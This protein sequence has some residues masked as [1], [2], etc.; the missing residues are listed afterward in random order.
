MIPE[1]LIDEVVE[2]DPTGLPAGS[3]K[4]GSEVSYKLKCTPSKL[5]AKKIIRNKYLLPA[6]PAD[7]GLKSKIVIAPIET[8]LIKNC[9]ADAS[10]LATLVIEKYAYHMPVYRQMQRFAQAGVKLA[11]STML[12]WVAKAANLLNPLYD[13]IK[14]EIIGADYLMMDETTMK[15]LDKAKKG[16]THRG[17]Y[18]AVQSP[19]KKMVYFEYHPGRGQEIPKAILKDFKGY[20]Q[21]DGYQVYQNLAN[22]NIELLCCMAHARRYFFESQKNDPLRAEYAL[23]VF[24]SLYAIEQDIKDADPKDRLEARLKQSKPIWQAFGTWLTENIVHLNEKSAIYK[25]FAYTMARFKRLAIY[26]DCEKLNIDNNPTE[27]SI[28]GIALG[29]KN[30]LFCG[31]HQAARRSA[32]LYSFMATCKLHQVN[33]MDW[34]TDV[35]G[36]ISNTK[37]DQLNQLLPQNWI[38]NRKVQKITPFRELIEI[39]F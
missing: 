7:A 18:W 22:E 32:M 36:R 13:H 20:L 11:H 27:S 1:A 10:L 33:L 12:D 30:F 24:R 3:V 31:S 38:K 5:S 4:I 14:S 2:L 15:V 19:E 29:R 9:M 8:G 16:T 25:A 35:L 23:E 6:D 26:M 17:Y 34:L 39:A 21:S 28:R 37:A